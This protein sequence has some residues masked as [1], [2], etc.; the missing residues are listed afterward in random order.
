MPV[1]EKDFLGNLESFLSRAEFFGKI[2]SPK[3]SF[4][5]IPLT[6]TGFLF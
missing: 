3:T 2:P 4:R 1:E 5:Q 6:K